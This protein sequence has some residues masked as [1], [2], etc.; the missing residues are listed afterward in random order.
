MFLLLR[1]AYLYEGLPRYMAE[2]LCTNFSDVYS[3]AYLDFVAGTLPMSAKKFNSI[4]CFKN[5]PVLITN[6]RPFEKRLNCDTAFLRTDTTLFE[7]LISIAPTPTRLQVQGAPRLHLSHQPRLAFAGLFGPPALIFTRGQ[8]P[9]HL[10]LRP[11]RLPPRR[12]RLH[13][14]AVARHPQDE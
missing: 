4:N 12:L 10:L 14:H 13:L 2:L 8:Q 11:P 7:T 3:Q 9:K 1:C 5:L 6:Y